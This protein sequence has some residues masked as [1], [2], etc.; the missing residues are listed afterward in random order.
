MKKISKIKS[1]SS[2]NIPSPFE[3][4]GH[5]TERSAAAVVM[6]WMRD[7]IG[8][9]NLDLGLPDVETGGSDQR[10]P[11]TV[12]NKTCR[13]QDVLCVMEFKSPQWDPMNANDPKEPARKKATSRRAPY[14]ATSNF[15]ELILWNTEKVNAGR[16]EEEQIIARYRLAEL[17]D[18]DQMEESRFRIPLQKGLEQ[19]VRDLTE[20]ATGKKS[21]PRHPIDELL[22]WRLQEKINKLSHYYRSIIYDQAHKDPQFGK[23]LQKWFTGQGWSFFIESDDD[24]QKISRQTA[25]LLANKILFYNA[26]QL[27]RTDKLDPLKIPEDITRGG[28][29]KSVLEG[30]FKEVLKI[31]YETIY[32]ADFIDEIAFPDSRE[33]VEEIRGL[34]DALQQYDF[35]TLGFDVIGRL[36]ER[37]IPETERHNLGQYF[38]DP[39]VV[40]IILQFCVRQDSD[41]VFDPSCGAG[42]FLV[43]AYQLKKLMNQRLSHEEILDSLWGND[44]A[45]FP[46][47]LAT[48]NL[49]INDLSGEK[50]YP[51][52]IRKDFFDLL[53]NEEDGIRLP[54]DVRNVLLKTM[55]AE[56]LSIKHPRRFDALAGNPPYTRQEEIA[57]ISGE[58]NY[59]D[60]LIQKA[61]TSSNTQIA[62]LS[63]RAGIYAYFFVH[64]FKFLRNGGRFGFIVSNAWLDVEYGAGLQEFFLHNFKIVAVIESK[65]ERW[66]KDADINTCIVILEKCAG[67][68]NRAERESN[69]ARFVQ[70]FKPLRQFIP[71][72]ATMWEEQIQRKQAVENL[73]KTILAHNEFYQNEEMRIYPKKQ[74]DLY[75]EGFDAEEQKYIGSKWGKYLRA[76]EIFFT[77]LEKGKGK[78]VPLK[79][80]ADVRFGIKTGAN[81]FF[82]LTEE[83]IK[84]RRIEKEFWMHKDEK[85]EWIPNFTFVKAN[86]SDTPKVESRLL[87]YRTIF[88]KKRR[89]E[90]KGTKV[91]EYIKTAERVG[92][93]LRPTCASRE[94][95]RDWFDVGDTIQDRVAFPERM[96]LRHIVFWNPER[97]LLNKNLY[98]IEP[99]QEG[100]AKSIAITLNSTITAL[101]TELFARQPGGGGGPL[102]IDVYVA[103][104]ILLPSTPFVKKHESAFEQISILEREM[105]DIFSELG[106]KAPDEFSLDKVKPDRRALDQIIMGDILGLTDAEQVEVYKAVIDLVKS[107]IERARSLG[108]SKPNK[109]GID[110]EAVVKIVLDKIDGKTL[111][112][113]YA[114][115]TAP[116]KELTQKKLPEVVTPPT[117]EKS[118]FGWQINVGGRKSLSC[119][120]ELEARYVKVWLE[121]GAETIKLPKDERVLKKLVPL[122]EFRK[123]EIDTI[124]D[125]Y[126]GS[127]LDKKLKSQILHQIWQRVV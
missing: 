64:G 46:A 28:L 72:A 10:F 67:A 59:K 101:Y 33:V 34:V 27:K 56:E 13:S 29:L 99:H 58:E 36:F 123:A 25:Y 32:T 103:S 111:K 17:F 119:A 45:K 15:R 14:F 62:F 97:A 52:V 2:G 90:L 35:S 69:L 95:A 48:I 126:L 63:R 114:E 75:D 106:A 53:S 41:T 60:K 61:L 78:L 37:L 8:S 55:S 24:Y 47:H 125:V 7:I 122:L 39:D 68:G 38:T 18:L 124:I 16:P 40:D 6:S 109:K 1:A 76:P 9:Q 21:A 49:A 71:P 57:E 79:Q 43:R 116:L 84:R 93:H 98:G 12:I 110:V 82:Y 91:M 118:L 112:Q 74:S 42:T 87:K 86:E 94:P 100:M 80:V 4:R 105:S 113:F 92:L 88:I 107:R 102:D 108:S 73:I 121:A 115:H 65:M 120:S 77:I 31:D 5:K 20:F 23:N 83:E 11:D 85:G 117:I 3:T 26:L 30:Y 66:F 44:I 96:R 50:N 19:F 81:E 51:R 22:I 89:A 127:I 70:L 104:D 54:E